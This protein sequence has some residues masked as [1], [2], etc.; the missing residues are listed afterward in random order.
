[1]V[2]V[3]FSKEVFDEAK[4]LTQFTAQGEGD[5]SKQTRFIHHATE[6]NELNHHYWLGSLSYLSYRFHRSISLVLSELCK[7]SVDNLQSGSI[8]KSKY[9]KAAEALQVDVNALVLSIQVLSHLLLEGAK[10]NCSPD[11]FINSLDEI[12]FKEEQKQAIKE[13]RRWSQMWATD[14]AQNEDGPKDA[15]VGGTRR[16]TSN[17]AKPSGSM[18]LICSHPLV[19]R[20]SFLLLSL[21]IFIIALFAFCW[22]TSPS[23]S[24]IITI[25]NG[26]LIFNFRRS[27]CEIKWSQF[28]WSNWRRKMA[29]TNPRS[30]YFNSIMQIWIIWWRSWRM[31]SRRWTRNIAGELFD[32]SN[33]NH[34]SPH[35]C[36]FSIA[37]CDLILQCTCIPQYAVAYMHW[38]TFDSSL[39]A[40]FFVVGVGAGVGVGVGVVDPSLSWLGLIRPTQ[41]KLIQSTTQRPHILYSIPISHTSTD[42]RQ[43]NTT[44]TLTNQIVSYRI[45][46]SHDAPVTS[47][48]S[49]T[50]TRSTVVLLFV[51]T[52][53]FSLSSTCFHLCRL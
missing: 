48:N 23:A 8:S 18:P 52:F 37:A 7:I 15:R 20:F 11:D 1:M 46:S 17:S 5:R 43:T 39:F 26:A 10:R 42:N 2:L 34:K 50:S 32:M 53:S 27:W 13:V 28:W 22:V 4:Q 47:P 38:A 51:F 31:Q 6:E 41:P 3:A 44:R 35:A 30:S 40:S 33:K 49:G 9:A 24:R 14:N 36:C 21:L 16:G 29:A 25:S 19:F 12:E 45:E